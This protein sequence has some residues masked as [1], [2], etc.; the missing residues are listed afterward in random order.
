MRSSGSSLRAFFAPTS[1]R[2][3]GGRTA[4]KVQATEASNGGDETL[5]SAD[6]GD[7]ASL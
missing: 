1:D 4:M 2:T 5:E 6:R 7:H 3:E